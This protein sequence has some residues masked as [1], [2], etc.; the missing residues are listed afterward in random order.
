MTNHRNY[1]QAD[2]GAAL[3]GTPTGLTPLEVDKYWAEL[4]TS[5]EWARV[6]DEPHLSFLA[7]INQKAI[8]DEVA[9]LRK[10]RSI[11]SAHEL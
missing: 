8:K 5:E 2:L 6:E 3:E 4:K 10:P 7:R 1:T 11:G 9:Q